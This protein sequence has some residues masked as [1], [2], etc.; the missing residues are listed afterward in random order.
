[1]TN[2][3]LDDLP[4]LGIEGR[5]KKQPVGGEER[6]MVRD[7]IYSFPTRSRCPECKATDT[8]AISTQAKVQYRECRKC[9]NTY[10]VIGQKI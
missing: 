1:M 10:T 9:G 8:I 5:K 3:F 2:G 6:R 7:D 4:D